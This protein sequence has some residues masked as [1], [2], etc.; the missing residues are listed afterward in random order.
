VL[1]F[2]F[3]L[4][5]LLASVV[6]GTPQPNICDDIRI[7]GRD[8][9]ICQAYRVA[10]NCPDRADIDNMQMACDTLRMHFGAG[11]FPCEVTSAP[12]GAASGA[13]TTVAASGVPTTAEPTPAVV[14]IEC[15]SLINYYTRCTTQFQQTGRVTLGVLSIGSTVCETLCQASGLGDGCCYYSVFGSLQTSNYANG[16]HFFPGD[17]STD[18]TAFVGRFD[19]YASTCVATG[20]VARLLHKRCSSRKTKRLRRLRRL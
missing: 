19:T 6:Q 12:S 8:K 15:G 2:T 7:T 5:L 18:P 17:V 9:G 10:I 1:R 20:P 13:P 11:T 16:C 4:A 14:N 3:L